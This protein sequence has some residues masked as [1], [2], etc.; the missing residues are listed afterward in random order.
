MKIRDAT[1]AEL[2]PREKK[3]RPLSPRQVAIRKREVII[4]KALEELARGDFG[5]I[6]RV[7]LEDGEKL[8]TIRAAIARQI[9]SQRSDAD[10]LVRNGAIYLRRGT[11]SRA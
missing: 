8:P 6:K 9:R 2:A 11:G 1:M 3:P 5:L 4:G 10:L 7:E